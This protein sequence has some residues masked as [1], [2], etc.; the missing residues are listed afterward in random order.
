MCKVNDS[1]SQHVSGVDASAEMIS[2][3]TEI[4]LFLS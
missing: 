2:H 3:M 4:E 1:S